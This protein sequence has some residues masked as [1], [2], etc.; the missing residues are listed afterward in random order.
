MGTWFVG[1][2]FFLPSSFSS[3]LFGLFSRQPRN[4]LMGSVF[5]D[6][7]LVDLFSRQPRNILMLLFVDWNFQ[8]GIYSGLNLAMNGL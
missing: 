6:W 2:C 7:N 4:R 5:V 1:T 8:I 3:A